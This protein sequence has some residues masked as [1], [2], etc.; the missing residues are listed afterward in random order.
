MNMELLIKEVARC[1]LA[2]GYL[3]LGHCTLQEFIGGEL[4]VSNEQLREAEK[5]LDSVLE[6]TK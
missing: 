3:H 2:H 5:Y 1:A 6:E 4:D